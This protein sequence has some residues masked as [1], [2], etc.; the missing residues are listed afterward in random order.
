MRSASIA[1]WVV[2][3]FTSKKRATSVVG[4]L[5]ELEPQKGL[6]W[7]WASMAGVVLSLSWRS[8]LGLVAAYYVRGWAFG[9]LGLAYFGKY[10]PDRPPEHLWRPTIALLSLFGTLW[11]PVIALLTFFGSLLWMALVY[12][13]IRYGLQDRVTRLAL[14]WTGLI[15]T[16]VFYWWQP[17]I[18]YVCLALSICV[19]AIS[20]LKTEYRK[21]A[22]IL[23]VT[24]ATGFGSFVLATYWSM[25][26][27]RMV[28]F[29]SGPMGK[30]EWQD[31][32]SV[33]WML[34]IMSF[35]VTWIA[36]TACS[37]MHYWLLRDKPVDEEAEEGM[38]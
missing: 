24:V 16:V 8:I 2:G 27:A 15:T 3:R 28:N 25:R 1:E 12:V 33:R 29:V 10:G 14:A 11:T 7:F 35:I 9:R 4:D 34:V 13:A 20:I 30:M 17:V 37:R 26:Y 19:A 31:H 23:L 5:V 32:A 22:L 21:A 38:A 36:T 18:L 6:L